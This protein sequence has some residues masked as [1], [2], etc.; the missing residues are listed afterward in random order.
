MADDLVRQRLENAATSLRKCRKPFIQKRIGSYDIFYL[1]GNGD[2]FFDGGVSP[3]W[4]LLNFECAPLN[5]CEPIGRQ[6]SLV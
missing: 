4:K 6:M 2:T 5:E 3:I 1:D